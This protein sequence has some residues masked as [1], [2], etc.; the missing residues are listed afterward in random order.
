[1]LNHQEGRITATLNAVLVRSRQ[2]AHLN[3]HHVM[4]ASILHQRLLRALHAVQDTT[5]SIRDKTT[6]T[7][8][9]QQASIL[10]QARLNAH[11]VMQASILQQRLL[12]ALHALLDITKGLLDKLLAYHV[13]QAH[14]ILHHKARYAQIATT[15]N[16]KKRQGRVNAKRAWPESLQ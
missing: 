10:Q 1:M 7:P 5:K 9:V 11:H 2:E 14:I 15:D 3:A 4:Q 13:R 6:A 12:H 16:T 8:H